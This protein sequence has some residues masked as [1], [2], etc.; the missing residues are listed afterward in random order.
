L[1]ALGPEIRSNGE[2]SIRL[3]FNKNLKNPLAEDKCLCM[4]FGL[5]LDVKRFPIQLEQTDSVASEYDFIF[6]SLK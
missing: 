6:R 2:A 4:L 1:A 3:F 5:L